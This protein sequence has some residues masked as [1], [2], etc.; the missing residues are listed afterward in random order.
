MVLDN[1]ITKF[2]QCPKQFY[3]GDSD[4]AI[5]KRFSNSDEIIK[6]WQEKKNG[7]TGLEAR[8]EME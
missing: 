1:F 7:V 6:D 5:L 4:C 3:H 8:R 2:I